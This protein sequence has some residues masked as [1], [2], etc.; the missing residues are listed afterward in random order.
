[1]KKTEAALAKTFSYRFTD[2]EEEEE[3]GGI[4]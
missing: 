1:M 2:E 3:G 4:K